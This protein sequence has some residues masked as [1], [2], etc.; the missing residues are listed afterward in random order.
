MSSRL[1]TEVREKRGLCYYVRSEHDSYHETG[2]FGASAGVDPTRVEEAV[3]VV[4]DEL[5]HLLDTSGPRAVTEAELKRS[6]DYLI[7]KTILSIED[8]ENVANSYGSEQLLLGKIETYKDMLEGVERVTLADV[9]RIAKALINPKEF[10]FAI[11][12][13]FKDKKVFEKILAA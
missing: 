9:R 6:K 4:R 11:I 3:K 12:G 10:R 8:T 2:T 1:F 5:L 7:G 13:P